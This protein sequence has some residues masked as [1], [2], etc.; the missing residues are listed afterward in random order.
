MR[1]KHINVMLVLLA[2]AYFI[3]GI[4]LADDYG[5][6]WDEPVSRFNGIITY[7]FVTEGDQTLIGFR[8]RFYGP[9]F[10]VVM[11]V[12]EKA[13]G[14]SD[15]Y[16]IFAL[17]HTA[18]FILFFIS[19]ICMYLLAAGIFG[20]WGWG[21]TGA[22][23][24]VLHPRLFAESFYNSKD[25]AFLASWIIA[26]YFGYRYV[27]QSTLVRA[28]CFG[29]AVALATDIRVAGILLH[30][31]GVAVGIRAFF[32]KKREALVPLVV[33]GFVSALC[34]V[35]WWPALWG[36]PFVR[37]IEAVRFVA[38]FDIYEKDVLYMGKFLAP[39]GIPWHYLP[40]W[41][42]ITTPVSV[43]ALWIMG[44][45][46]TLRDARHFWQSF[47][48]FWTIGILVLVWLFGPALYDGWRQ[49]YF[50]YP[51]MVMTALYGLQWLFRFPWAIRVAVVAVMIV[52]IGVAALFI[53]RN[54]PHQ[55]VYFN[56]LV[57]GV[58]GAEA[59]FD[60]D[61]WGVSYRRG[62]EHIATID[63]RQDIKV[64]FAFGIGAHA[65]VLKKPYRRFIPVN[66]LDEADYILS[67]FRWQKQKPPF[68]KV[69][70]V[71]VDGVPIM[72]VYTNL[73]K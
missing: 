72:G 27:R 56:E 43:I 19:V 73:L 63:Q 17:R 20:G 67:N 61:Y 11:Y 68:P 37:F 13:T 48:A 41:I 64:F 4:R 2:A 46:R 21:V 53:V 62:L 6:G 31:I 34:T 42:G 40:V 25:I 10:E 71:K 50:I 1:L 3:A 32:G 65:D 47:F 29:L 60:L 36:N 28:V 57:G 18:T 14:T 24:L 12:F 54:H 69:Y 26:V 33:Y 55:Y 44:L 59:R 66:H 23:L 22:L 35:A 9:A 39:Q 58:R 7:R 8:D 38:A 70:E 51:A 30:V 45:W 15:P 5:L 52:N 16:A 49:F